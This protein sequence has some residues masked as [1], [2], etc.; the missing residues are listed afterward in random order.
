MLLEKFTV[1]SMK[2]MMLKYFID[3]ICGFAVKIE[4]ET[5]RHIEITNHNFLKKVL[6]Q[7]PE[8][9]IVMILDNA[10]IHH[11]KLLKPFLDENKD[12]LELM[13][14]PAYSPELN[15]LNLKDLNGLSLTSLEVLPHYSKFIDRFDNFE[16]ILEASDSSYFLLNAVI[17]SMYKDSVSLII[18]SISWS[19][20]S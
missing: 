6:A 16:E 2:N 5:N 11:A 9:K 14:L 3:D 10:R 17:I 1:K 20:C 12:R 8:G 15:F 18:L 13:F 19:S 7:Y 4:N